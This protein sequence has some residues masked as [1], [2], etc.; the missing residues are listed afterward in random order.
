MLSIKAHWFFLTCS[1]K[2]STQHTDVVS[3]SVLQKGAPS[4]L[5]LFLHVFYRECTQHIHGV[6]LCV[7]TEHAIT[8][9]VV[10]LDVFYHSMNIEL[11]KMVLILHVLYQSKHSAHWCCFFMCFIKA[12][13][14]H[15]GAVSSQALSE[16]ALRTLVLFLHVFS[17]SMHSAH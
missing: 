12:C 8:K 5:V 1:I 10:F 13:T 9:L 14:Q 2:A 16:H 15:N 6:Y 3:S 11:S 7:L 4:A 17:H